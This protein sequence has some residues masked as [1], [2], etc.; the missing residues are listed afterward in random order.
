[1]S[2]RAASDCIRNPDRTPTDSTPRLSCV[3]RSSIFSIKGLPHA[4]GAQ[5]APEPSGL[6]RINLYRAFTESGVPLSPDGQHSVFSINALI[7]IC[8]PEKRRGL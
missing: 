7:E 3:D 8:T 5:I 1:L 6:V 2:G 4:D